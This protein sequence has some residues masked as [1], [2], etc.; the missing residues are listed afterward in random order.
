MHGIGL[1]TGSLSF[2][3][4]MYFHSE[5]TLPIR[6]AEK[7]Q[8]SEDET[9][10]EWMRVKTIQVIVCG[11]FKVSF[12]GIDTL[13]S[14]SHQRIWQGLGFFT[15]QDELGSL[16]KP[17]K[18]FNDSARVAGP[19]LT[20]FLEQEATMNFYFKIVIVIVLSRSNVFFYHYFR[21]ERVKFLGLI[22][23]RATVC[24]ASHFIK[25]LPVLLIFS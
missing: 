13:L 15:E 4:R 22:M 3:V 7:D 5:T 2:L 9:I 14:A 25:H 24:T 21:T 23:N 20:R 11:A 19:E 18:R 8:D 10:P 12:Q 1:L 16:D 17:L 6:T